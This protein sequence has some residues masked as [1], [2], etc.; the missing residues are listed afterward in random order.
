MLV[1]DDADAQRL[2]EPATAV[3]VVRESLIAHHNGGLTAPPRVQASLGDG[4]LIF[5]AGRLAG[6]GYGFRVYRMTSSGSGNR[7]AGDQL[8]AVYDDATGKLSGAIIGDFLGTARTGAIGAVAV[9]V[10]AR[11]DA[12]TV[13]LIG[14]GRQA[15]TQLWAIQAVR[16]L[17]AARVYS[18]DPAG[19][20]AFARRAAAELGVPA[21]A[22]E[23]PAAAVDGADIVVL[24][25]TSSQPVIEAEWVATGAHVSTLGPKT[26]RAHE[27][28][29]GLADRAG[30]ILTDSPAQLDA[31]AE[32]LF[33]AG[34]AR[35]RVGDLGAAVAGAGPRRDTSDQITLFL[36]VGLAG[37]EVAVAA[38]LLRAGR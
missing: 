4:D 24:A 2:L 29:P 27:C 21:S 32:P 16:P 7:L 22:V 33:L 14:S 38:E 20:E 18:R 15:W 30:V 3:A 37:T 26:A 10:L 36:S 12:G 28:P 6:T 31:S 35:Q 25:T 17:R 19:R 11:P 34:A 9:D 1:L 23:A 13:G 8:T 5:T